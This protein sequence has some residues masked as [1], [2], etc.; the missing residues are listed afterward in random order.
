MAICGAF[1]VQF[2]AV[3]LKLW[4]GEKVLSPRYIFIG[5][6]AID[7]PPGIDATEL[8][9]DNTDYL[10][11]VVLQPTFFCVKFLSKISGVVK[12]PRHSNSWD[13]DGQDQERDPNFRL[14]SGCDQNVGLIQ[15]QVGTKVVV[16]NL[17]NVLRKYLKLIVRLTQVYRK[18]N[19]R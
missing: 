2:F 11:M 10:L 17:H 15:I 9:I 4:G 1:L 12:H 5:G 14:E 7:P 3:Q 8:Y 18:I 16:P 13:Q 19:V 6:G